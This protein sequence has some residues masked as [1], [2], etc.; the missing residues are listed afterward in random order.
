MKLTITESDFT[1]GFK[2]MGREDQFSLETLKALF[3]YLVELDRDLN[4]ESEFD[5]IAIC[6]EYVEVEKSDLAEMENYSS[7]DIV[8]TTL[9]C[10]VFRT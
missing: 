6:C 8:V 1:E 3:E 4:Q 2:R 7:C 9:N 5:V 10:V